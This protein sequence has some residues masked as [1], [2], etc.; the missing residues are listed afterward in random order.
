MW[1]KEPVNDNACLVLMAGLPGS[2]KSTVAKALGATLDWPV[3][4]KDV[5]LSG[6]L[7]YDVPGHI[8]QPASYSTLLAL[9]RDLVV[10]QGTSVILDSPASEEDTITSAQEICREGKAVLRVVLCLADRDTRNERVRTRVAQRSQPVGV[11][12]TIGTG[13]ERFRHL[14]PETLL[15]N[16]NQPMKSVMANVLD[17]LRG[18]FKATFA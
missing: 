3:I 12:T 1:E 18:Q 8:A 15:L 14:P 11:S 10:S 4:D 6:L 2:G 17:H 7:R 9:G 13:I 5:I 16:T